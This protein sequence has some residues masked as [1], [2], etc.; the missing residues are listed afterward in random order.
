MQP[1]RI[2]DIFKEPTEAEL[3]EQQ[4][5]V[6]NA[7]KEM[8]VVGNLARDCINTGKFQSYKLAFEKSK[9]KV[10]DMLMHHKAP[11]I[12][13]YGV[14]VM[15]WMERLRNLSALITALE[16]DARKGKT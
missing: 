8:Q 6:E 14:Q 7:Q 11:D 12:T 1:N 2:E 16:S 10:M 3:K 4:A 9:L 13:S 15:V 5:R